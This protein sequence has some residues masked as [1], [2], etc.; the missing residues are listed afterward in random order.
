MVQDAQQAMQKAGAQ[1]QAAAKA[2][3]KDQPPGQHPPGQPTPA[4]SN[5]ALQQA[6]QD[7]MNAQNALQQ[8]ALQMQQ[9]AGAM[10]QQAAASQPPQQDKGPPSDPS[11]TP[12]A[13]ASKDGNRKGGDA[14]VRAGTRPGS[15]GW[16]AAMSE[17]GRVQLGQDA[18]RAFPPEYAKRL[19]GYYRRLGNE[20][21]R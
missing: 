15:P 10:Q 16:D 3:T 17:R 20:E 13:Q 19:E 9:A 11:G 1:L 7:M 18:D 14:T 8:A 2:M 5:P 6:K 4:P 21:E 12:D